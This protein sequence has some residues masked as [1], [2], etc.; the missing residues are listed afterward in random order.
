MDVALPRVDLAAMHPLLLWDT[1]IPATAAVF[2]D[3]RAGLPW[4]FALTVTD[5][6]GF[7]SGELRLLVDP[8]CV[9]EDRIRR[10]CAGPMSHSD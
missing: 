1:I 9:S 3:T 5:V 4:A 6:P 2:A 7:G 10:A 8:S